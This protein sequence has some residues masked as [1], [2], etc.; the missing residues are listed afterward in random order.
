[1]KRILFGLTASTLLAGTA[2]SAAVQATAMTDLNLRASPSPKAEIVNVIPGAEAVEVKACLDTSQWC[3]VAYNGQNGWAYGAYLSAK[4]ADAEEPVV[5]YENRQTLEIATVENTEAET[6]A[7]AG[8]GFV[9]ALAGGLLGGPAG[10]IAGGIAAGATADAAVPSEVTTYVLENRLEPVYLE[11]EVVTGAIVPE[12]VELTTIPDSEY[13][14]LY[15]N[16][17]PA[18]VDAEERVIVEIVRQ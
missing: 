4:P 3:E 12:E 15:V 5:V 6:E 1:M 7:A 16:G 2:A 8:A 9:G 18:V 14:Y 11:G 13:A 17:V 10:A